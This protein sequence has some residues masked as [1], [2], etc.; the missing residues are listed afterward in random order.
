MK[1]QSTPV[2]QPQVQTPPKQA[3]V[4]AQQNLQ[5]AAKP[6]NAPAP[7]KAPANAPQNPAHLGKNVDTH[8]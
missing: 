6:A 3:A 5:A 2:Q 8:A 1:V 4:Q 7:P